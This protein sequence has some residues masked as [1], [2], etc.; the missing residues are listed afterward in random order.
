[1]WC[2]AQTVDG[3]PPSDLLTPPAL[4]AD[5]QPTY[6]PDALR[7]NVAGAVTLDLDIDDVGQVMRAAVTSSPDARLSWAALGAVT[8]MEFVAAQQTGQNVAVRVSY[9]VNFAIDTVARERL[10]S[11]QD[12]LRLAEL[13]HTTAVN[14]RGR[15]RVAGEAQDLAGAA[16]HIEDPAHTSVADTSSDAHGAFELAG[17]PPGTFTVHVEASGFYDGNVQQTFASNVVTELVIYLERKPS[18][19]E[20]VVR[21]K[22]T[23]HE[24]SKRTLT[25]KELTRVPGT[26]GDPIRVVQRLPGVQRAPFGLG[27]LLIRGG[28]PE[29]STI[30]IDGHLTRLLFHLGA[31]PSVI[32]PDLLQEV[33]LY[34]GGQG[35]RYGR[36]IAGAVD[37]VTRD[38]RSDAFSGKASVDLLQ[39]GFRLEGPL[40]FFR[41]SDDAPAK[42]AFFV[43]GRT[44]YVADVLNVGNVITQFADVPVN[45]LTLAPRYSDYQFKLLWKLP[46]GGGF[47]QS[48]VVNWFGSVDTLNFALDAAELPPQVPSSVGIS[49]G[50]HRLNPVWRLRCAKANDDGTAQ[51]SA[52]VS[53]LIETNYSENR[54]DTSQFRLDVARTSLRAELE[55]RPVSGL[56]FLFGTDDTTAS[57]VST[58]DVPQLL[59]DERLFP[60]PALSDPPRFLLKD[61]VQGTSVS[62]YQET[63]AAMGPLSTVFGVRADLLSYYDQVRTSLDPRMNVKL[64]LLHDL[65]TLKASVGGYHQ[66]PSPFA[67]AH[68]FGNPALPLERGTQGSLGA[69]V[70]LSDSFDVDAQAFGR[71]ADDLADFVV[72]PLGFF[73]SGAARVQAITHERVYGAELLVRQRPAPMPWGKAFGW[74]AYTLMR[75][76]ERSDA[77]QGVADAR[78]KPWVVGQFDQTHIVSIAL[79][80]ELPWAFE[81]GGAFR[82]VTGNP[83]TL[84]QS[85]LY[86][87]DASRYR[88]V[89]GP[90]RAARLPDFIQL[91]VRVDKRF[92]FD[93][94]QLGLFVDVQ[95]ATNQQNF[96]FFAYSYDYA[97]VQGFPGLPILPVVGMDAS[98]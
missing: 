94:W 63:D 12:A 36:A 80:T 58:T 86:D 31:G 87:A 49:L 91:D 51:L 35:A 64:N 6:P 18:Q 78:A 93:T 53:P 57:F 90:R 79:S 26:F 60:R 43:A 48:L 7:D 14:L 16:V 34:P 20:T 32:N 30:L 29:D 83:S 74:V 39:T 4:I 67:L 88:P 11:T 33:S 82:Y 5:A 71:G 69:Q 59:P 1:M 73:A 61:T 95:N 68:K 15:V 97:Q 89:N 75:A 65:V 28:G 42:M 72:N 56:G 50:F 92:T 2:A 52:T 45:T 38:P 62:F 55:F 8:N 13:T 24:V 22:R 81:V 3:A 84:A 85:G 70:R 37:V 46:F 23:Q 44:S 17:V 25:Q 76:E 96:E 40:P 47:S 66:S 19:A 27:A 21:E 9:T 77:P 41:A 54:F 98:F 10:M